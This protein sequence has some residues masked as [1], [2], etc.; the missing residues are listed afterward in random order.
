MV[1]LYVRDYLK[2]KCSPELQGLTATLKNPA[3]EIS[4]SMAAV[5][6]LCKFINP[7]GNMNYV[8][9]GDG[10]RCLTGAFLAYLT[11]GKVW[12]IDP[13][14]NQRIVQEWMSAHNVL[15]FKPIPK[16]FQDVQVKNVDKNPVAIVLVHA[17]VS[18]SQVIQKF[19][20]WRFIYANPCCH[21]EIQI[22]SASYQTSFGIQC[23]FAGIDDNI[24]SEKNHIFIYHNNAKFPRD[25]I[26]I[27]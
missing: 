2:K 22:L 23:V 26:R 27:Y 8:V 17:H 4:E 20:N 7:H 19:P 16:K 13:G 18:V 12:S 25:E 21:P 3:K 1:N 10:S 15:R 14:I 5:N 11:K 24:D 9:I 6:H